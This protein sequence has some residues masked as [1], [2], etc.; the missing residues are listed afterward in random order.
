ML[1]GTMAELSTRITNEI[2]AYIETE[3]LGRQQQEPSPSDF[4]DD[5]QVILRLTGPRQIIAAM[6]TI[7]DGNWDEYM[8]AAWHMLRSIDSIIGDI[9][10]I[11]GHPRQNYPPWILEHSHKSTP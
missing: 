1:S 4:K 3:T 8:Y 2:V 10:T 9:E 6:I 5:I 7:G 11:D